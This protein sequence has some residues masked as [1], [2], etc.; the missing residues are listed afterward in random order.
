MKGLILVDVPEHGLRC[1]EYVDLSDDIG[2][3]LAS[4]GR[5]DTLAPDPAAPEA[6]LTPVE[7]PLPSQP[8]GGDAGQQSD[9]L[10]SDESKPQGPD[11]VG[12]E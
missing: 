5:L 11:S 9:L 6:P 2:E 1:G 10:G 12:K 8:P 3:L 4:D 7:P